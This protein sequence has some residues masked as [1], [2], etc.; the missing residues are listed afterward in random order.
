M[1]AEIHFVTAKIYN[2]PQSEEANCFGPIFH[3]M[4]ILCV[5]Q[6]AIFKVFRA[7]PMGPRGFV[8]LE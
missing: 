3:F 5:S 4:L 2:A 8:Q 7:W 6:S 1:Q